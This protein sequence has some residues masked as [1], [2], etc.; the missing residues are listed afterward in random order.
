LEWIKTK[1]GPMRKLKKL[2]T[3]LKIWF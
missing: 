2:V 1:I 3:K